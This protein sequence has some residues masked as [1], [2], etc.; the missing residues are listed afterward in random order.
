MAF[1]GLGAVTDP[2]VTTGGPPGV[3]LPPWLPYLAAL[4]GGL[5]NARGGVLGMLGG[6]LS[7]YAQARTQQGLLPLQVREAQADIAGKETG[8]ELSKAQIP[9]EQAKTAALQRGLAPISPQVM[10]QLDT[11]AQTATEPYERAY[12]GTVA[13]AAHN[14]QLTFDQLTEAMKNFAADKLARAQLAQQSMYYNTALMNQFGVPPPPAGAPA[15]MPA[16]ATPA[17]PGGPGAGGATGGGGFY[18]NVGGKNYPASPRADGNYWYT[19]DD[20]KPHKFV[21]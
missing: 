3:N 20:G 17:A 15:A 2:S 4:G 19:G 14:G 6:G 11:L 1:G 18:V 12:I 7:G 21:P 16:P 10:A 9:E 13:A 8:T 5:Q